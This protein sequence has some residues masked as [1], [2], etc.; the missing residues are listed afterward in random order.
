MRLIELWKNKIYVDPT[1]PT[2]ICTWQRILITKNWYILTCAVFSTDVHWWANQALSWLQRTNILHYLNLW[3]NSQRPLPLY[4]A[5]LT[6]L[7]LTNELKFDD[8][9]YQ[10][11]LLSLVNLLF[12]IIKFW[13][14]CERQPCRVCI[15][16][17]ISLCHISIDCEANLV[18]ECSNPIAKVLEFLL[19][20]A[21]SPKCL[22]S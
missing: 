17:K 22:L 2:Y 5:H 14:I 16:T 9:L 10:I 3:S 7:S 12:L 11:N 15:I 13:F 21:K 20:C 4:N 18:Q 19:P 8:Y 1:I 6:W